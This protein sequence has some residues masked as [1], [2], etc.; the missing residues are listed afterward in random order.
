MLPWRSKACSTVLDPPKVEAMLGTDHDRRHV[1]QTA[2]VTLITKRAS[3]RVTAEEAL[4]TY[5][6]LASPDSLL[7]RTRGWSPDRYEAWLADSL[8]RLVLDT[9]EVD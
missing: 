5:W 1:G 3:L 9:T 4:D 6:S 8:A 7:V 2:F